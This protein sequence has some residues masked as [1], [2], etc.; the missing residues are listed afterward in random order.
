ESDPSDALVVKVIDYGV[1]KVL[2]P[3][4]EIGAEQTQAGFVGTPAFASP[5][6][7]VSAAGES[8]VDTR[9]DI[10]SLGVT[11]WYLLTGRVPFL[12]GSMEDIRSK[13]QK[14]P[15]IE[16]LRARHV[17]LQVVSLLKSML[18]PDPERQ[19][20]ICTRITFSSSS[21]LR[22]IQSRST[23]KTTARIPNESWVNIGSRRDRW[24]YLVAAARP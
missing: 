2:A 8:H 11:L 15:P 21:V 9:S 4:T 1:A 18:A 23:G 16:Q 13:Q 6:Q 24:N 19:A 14:G 10:Y 5:E 22:A 3:Q 17:P 7:F 12:G 20:A